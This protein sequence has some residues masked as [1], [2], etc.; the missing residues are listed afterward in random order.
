MS[1]AMAWHAGIAAHGLWSISRGLA[2]GVEHP[3]E[4]KRMMDA[5]DEPPHGDLDGRGNLSL[6]ALRLR[7]A[8]DTAD[9]LFPRLFYP[10]DS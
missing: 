1:H 2:R 7:F 3:G 4:Y 6:L 10:S 8:A 5:A 9:L